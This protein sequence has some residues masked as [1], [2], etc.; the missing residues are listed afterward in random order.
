MNSFRKIVLGLIVFGAFA[1]VAPSTTL[2][3]HCGYGWGGRAYGGY[4]TY[5]YSV[6]PYSYGYSLPAYAYRA[7]AYPTAYA[8]R[9]YYAYRPSYR[10]YYAPVVPGFYAPAYRPYYGFGPGFNPYYGGP[11]YG[12]PCYG[13][14]SFYGRSFYGG[15]PGIGLYIY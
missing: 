2:A 13:G 5:H 10:P 6:R 12:G 8:Y 15:G 4:R 3:D 7:Y 11:Y 14:R 1:C 9:P